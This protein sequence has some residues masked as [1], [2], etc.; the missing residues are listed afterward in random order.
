MTNARPKERVI[1]V[2]AIHNMVIMSS[3]SIT[4]LLFLAVGLANAIR[5]EA[6]ISFINF[7]EKNVSLF[8]HDGEEFR[9]AG[10]LPPYHDMIMDTLIGHV[11]GYEK[12]EGNMLTY[13]VEQET[14]VRVFLGPSETV[15]VV[16]ST[17]TGAFRVTVVPT[18]SPRGAARFLELVTE[19]YFDGCALDLIVK[20]F[21]AQFGIGADYAQ[22][23]EYRYNF[24]MDDEPQ[25]TAF[26]PGYM[27][28][29]GHGANSRSNEVFIVLPGTSQDQLDAFGSQLWETPFGYVEEEDLKA[30]VDEWYAYGDAPPG[31]SGP[32]ID[33]IYREDGYEYLRREFPEMSYI[34]EC[35][36]VS[37]QD[38]DEEE[39]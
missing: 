29:A 16:C 27:T 1:T 35:H 22:R 11:F 12:E 2:L 26:Q 37:G 34:H 3:F 36:I 20:G 21:V 33:R 17:T 14:D 6:E 24:I 28:Y 32:V 31:G 23:T 10:E 7:S 30:V 38:E 4:R 15:S 9:P 13:T 18:W 25:G 39:L 19:K 5:Y 8:W